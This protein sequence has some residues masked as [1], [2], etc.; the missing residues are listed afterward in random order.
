MEIS[1]TSRNPIGAQVFG[2][3]YYRV[4]VEHGDT[5]ITCELDSAG[6][7]KE[8]AEHLATVAYENMSIKEIFSNLKS[9]GL[10]DDIVELATEAA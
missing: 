5:I 4:E 9:S 1:I 7:L 10:L 6:E 2:L 3:K 8:F